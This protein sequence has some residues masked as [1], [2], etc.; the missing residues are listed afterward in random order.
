M[1]ANFR[2]VEAVAVRWADLDAIGHVNH[3]KLFTYC[4]VA[5]WTYFARL[6]MASFQTH[7]GI[8]PAL[9]S[10]TLDFKRQLHYPATVLV[11][12]RTTTLGRSSFTLA[13]HLELAPSATA[14]S[15]AS[16]PVVIGSGH[17]VIVWTDYA[18]G[19]ALVLPP[20]LRAAFSALEG[21]AFLTQNLA[22]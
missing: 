7:P 11:G 19:R 8:G 13:Y 22:G 3:A 12:V 4:E 20:G 9:V 14:D 2:H 16:E 15:A 21:Q 5:R 10:A 18:A 1:T 17:S 6:G